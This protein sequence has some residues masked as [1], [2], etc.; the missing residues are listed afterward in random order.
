MRTN[1]FITFALFSAL[2]CMHG[3]AAETPDKVK[4][5]DGGSYCEPYEENVCTLRMCDREARQ[6]IDKPAPVGTPC[7]LGGYPEWYQ[8]NGGEG[9]CG[10]VEGSDG[11]LNVGDC[12][13]ANKIGEPCDDYNICT[14]ND[15]CVPSKF[16]TEDAVLG[17]CKAEFKE[18]M[19]CDNSNSAV[20]NSQ[21]QEPVGRCVIAD[22]EWGSGCYSTVL[23]GKPCDDY[24]E[25]TKDDLCVVEEGNLFDNV[26]IGECRGVFDQHLPCDI[27]GDPDTDDYCKAECDYLPNGCCE[28]KM[29]Q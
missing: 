22:N 29:A 9:T 25:C 1:L 18:G 14:V 11:E 3:I 12:F 5:E 24:N 4:C 6:C 2:A 15:T 21:C 19:E 7:M 28:P 13:A 23:Q 26:G 10:L 16:S 20:G 8:C 17:T 27:D